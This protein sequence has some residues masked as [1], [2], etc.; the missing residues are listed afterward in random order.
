MNQN[1]NNAVGQT[2]PNP[3]PMQSTQ[4]MQARPMGPE[5]VPNNVSQPNPNNA[6]QFIKE[7]TPP[8]PVKKKKKGLSR[9]L[10]TIIGVLAIAAILYFTYQ[11]QLNKNLELKSSIP[12]AK[13]KI[14]AGSRITA[15]MIEYI[16]VPASLL[17]DI[18]VVTSVDGIIGKYVNYDTIIPE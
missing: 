1:P 16:K 6:S 10:V 14:K 2:A 18:N 3:N 9:E 11:Y 4:P 12:I 8:Q 17:N 7:T 5:G 13:V 15:D